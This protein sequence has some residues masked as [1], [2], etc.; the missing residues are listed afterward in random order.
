[1]SAAYS[2]VFAFPIRIAPA[3]LRRS[4]TTASSLGT[5]SC[6]ISEPKVVLRPLVSMTSL[7][8]KGTPSNPRTGSPAAILRSASP[9]AASASGLTVQMALTAG[10]ERL[11][12]LQMSPDESRSRSRSC[13]APLRSDSSMSAHESWA[14][15]VNVRLYFPGL[16]SYVHREPA[17]KR[18]LPRCSMDM[19]GHLDRTLTGWSLLSQMLLATRTIWSTGNLLEP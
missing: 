4:T 19:R 16:T 13:S 15:H 1:M 6:M 3:D 17:H 14:R 5:K 2:G 7:T 8:T 12:S 18:Y 9:A 10:F 11:D